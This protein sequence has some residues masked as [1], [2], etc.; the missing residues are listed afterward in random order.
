MIVKNGKKILMDN[1]N[2]Y[3]VITG[4]VD[5]KNTKSLYFTIS[6]WAKPKHIDPTI[7]YDKVIRVIT[8]K[9]KTKLFRE[10]DVNLFYN[11]RT[12]VDFDM[13]KSGI[14]Y[15]KRSY[16]NCEITLFKKNNLKIQDCKINNS[17]HKLIDS[18]INNVLNESEHFYFFKNKK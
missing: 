6:G 13:R 15:T 1:F 17:L 3:N 9:I 8:K 11:N 4:T 12:I 5:N 14:S 18:I 16:M 7:N 10:I 2:N